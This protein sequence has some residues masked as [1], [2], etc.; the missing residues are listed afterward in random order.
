[1]NRR[2]YSAPA[3][4]VAIF[5]LERNY[6]YSPGGANL[7]DDNNEVPVDDGSENF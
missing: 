6:V 3:A 7:N 2:N 1:M 5:L 4:R